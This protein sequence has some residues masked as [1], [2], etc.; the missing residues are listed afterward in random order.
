MRTVLGARDGKLKPSFVLVQI[1]LPLVLGITAGLFRFGVPNSG[2]LLTGVSIVA[3]L[4]CGV[5]TLLFQ[6]RVDLRQKF[7]DESDAF[8]TD[9]DLELVDELFA[10]VMWAILSG[11][12]LAFLLVMK[13]ALS[14][15][16]G[17]VDVVVRVGFG[18][19]WFLVG[20]LVLT[21]GV[22]LKRMRSV[23]YRVAVHRRDFK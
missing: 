15:I 23:C 14:G 18:L 10:Q 2:E 6:T 17:G 11:F 3:A 16:L 8:L 12:L 1:G 20:N 9:D 7:D 21:V 19:T 22:V 5:T 13:G 4:M